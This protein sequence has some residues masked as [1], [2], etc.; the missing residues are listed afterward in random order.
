MTREQQDQIDYLMGTMHMYLPVRTELRHKTEDERR[1]TK[2]RLDR[3][4]D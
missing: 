3:R 1:N 2:K 4:S